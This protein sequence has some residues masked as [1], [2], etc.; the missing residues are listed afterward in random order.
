MSNVHVTSQQRA[1]MIAFAIARHARV[2]IA[3]TIVNARHVDVVASTHD[4]ANA[5][6]RALQRL[7]VAYDRHAQRFVV[8]DIDAYVQQRIA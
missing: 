7:H 2:T 3:R 1:Y 6:E 5:I 4:D 8:H